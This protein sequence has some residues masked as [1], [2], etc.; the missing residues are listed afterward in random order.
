M[1][2]LV[3][4]DGLM[5]ILAVT[6]ARWAWVF[7]LYDMFSKFSWRRYS[8]FCTVPEPSGPIRNG[9]SC[10]CFK[11]SGLTLQ[12][13]MADGSGSRSYDNSP[14]KK[15]PITARRVLSGISL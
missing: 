14:A 11:T 8:A 5:S 9:F 15:D 1:L 4:F 2:M 3:L 6:L 13:P 7:G 12:L 10:I